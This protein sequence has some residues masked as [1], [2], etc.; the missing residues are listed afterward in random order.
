M[1]VDEQRL[2]DLIQLAQYKMLSRDTRSWRS[3]T[4]VL[5]MRP[6]RTDTMRYC[7]EITLYCQTSSHHTTCLCVYLAV[8]CVWWCA[9]G[10]IYDWVLLLYVLLLGIMLP[11]VVQLHLFAGCNTVCLCIPHAASSSTGSY[12]SC[13]GCQAVHNRDTSRNDAGQRHLHTVPQTS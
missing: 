7:I 13:N 11:G 2:Q 4:M 8:M 5:A 12:E 9:S 3:P 10:Y 1:Q 6:K